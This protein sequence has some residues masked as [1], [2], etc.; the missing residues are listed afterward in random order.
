MNAPP[1]IPGQP[2]AT[3]DDPVIAGI[4]VLSSRDCG[5]LNRWEF[6]IIRGDEATA[7]YALFDAL[8]D[9]S[10]FSLA[11]HGRGDSESCA[12]YRRDGKVY[13]TMVGGHGWSGEWKTLDWEWA[14]YEAEKQV[15]YSYGPGWHNCGHL[16]KEK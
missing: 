9:F 5:A 7:V 15:K 11:D 3:E 8:K 13:K 6:T 4:T 16:I 2:A 12:T 10:E 14:L 1:T